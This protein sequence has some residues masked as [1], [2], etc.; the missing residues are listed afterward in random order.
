MLAVT[1]NKIFADHLSKLTLSFDAWGESK[2]GRQRGIRGGAGER[3]E[4]REG[5]SGEGTE[6]SQGGRTDGGKHGGHGHA[7]VELQLG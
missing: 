5:G 3:G 7:V 1:N 2:G 4:G 6:G